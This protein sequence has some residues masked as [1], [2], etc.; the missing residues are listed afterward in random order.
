MISLLYVDDEPIFLDLAKRLLEVP[1]EFFV[2]TK[3]SA[4]EGLEALASG[5]F[6]AI[7]A[8][9]MMPEMDGIV[10]LQ[11][12]R[13]EF[14]KIPFIM[15]TGKGREEIVIRALNAGADFYLQ[16]TGKPQIVFSEL[17]HILKQYVSLQ[18]T[19]KS[20]LEREERYHDLQNANDLIQ[21]VG[22]DG[23]FLYVNKKWLD[24]LGYEEKD[25]AHLAIFD[26]IHQESLSHCMTTFRRVISGENVGIVDAIFK[27]RDGKKVYVEGIA[28]CKITDGK[29]QYTR[30]IFKDVTDR[31]TAEAAL[32]ESEE[33]FRT[34]V[35]TT[36]DIVWEVDKDDRYTYVSPQVLGI[37]GYTPEEVIG[38]SC[39]DLMAPGE[40]DNIR[41]QYAEMVS[42]GKPIVR[43]ENTNLHK[44]GR[45]VILETSGEPVHA[46]DGS[47]KGYR[48]I[49][50][51]ITERK[52]AEKAIHQSEQYLMTLL[53][54]LPA[55]V[56]VVDA[57]TH[58]I[59]RANASALKLS[60]A[61][62]NDIVG[63][64]CHQFICPSA[65]GQCPITDKGMTLDRSER[66]LLTA[67]GGQVPVLKSVAKANLNGQEVLVETFVDISDS[68]RAE[69][70][71]R[72][73]E[74]RY[75]MLVENANEAIFVIQDG[76]ICFANPKLEQMGKYTTEELAQRPF[77][78]FVH[79]D[80]RTMVGEQH[81]RR[82]TGE[83]L[84]DSYA[85]RILPK[86]GS[87]RWMEISSS[88]ITWNGRAA[89]LVLLSDITERRQVEEALHESEDKFRS[90]VEHALDGILILDLPGTIL[91]AN[92]A[93]ARTIEADEPA[94]FIGRNVMEFISPES[95]E[96]VMKDFM[97]VSQGHD[98]YLAH[99]SVTSLRGNRYWVES[100]GK[101][102]NFNKKPAILLSIRDIT[103]R[104]RAD[105]A[106][107]QANKQ[108]YLLSGITRHD[109]LN[110]LMALKGYLELS[111]EV[112]DN[113]EILSEYIKNE[114]LAANAIEHQ[115][116]FTKDYQELGVAAPVWQNVGECTRKAAARLPMRRIHV[117]VVPTDLEI[118][119]DP[120]FET[121]FY[122]LIDNS[123]RYGG[124]RMTTIR[125]SSQE[126]EDHLTLAF[127]DDGAGI[128]AEDKK[129]LFT[130]GFG[131]N[132]GL[133]LFLSR[134]ILAITGIMISENSVPG[135]GTRFEITVPNG[136]FRFTGSRE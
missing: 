92:N 12:V 113:P 11:Q 74:D 65:E 88:L 40:A 55:G 107:R 73:S 4:R 17:K 16:K 51:D 99:Y 127:E 38:K 57:V 128:A 10:F 135:K 35:E 117:D 50:R 90:L 69:E 75:R 97:Q 39:F 18:Q 59:L 1:G 124:D 47:F 29:P 134:E 102:I 104:K 76:R 8:D 30:G 85:F 14:G 6:D 21:S 68:K 44:D 45:Q 103:E 13:K 132:T 81:N 3:S 70:A 100:I 110:Q 78:E 94:G 26:I 41:K 48:G 37:L 95:R 23:R 62:V 136:A 32:R 121:V 114:Q 66:I 96:D 120:L 101:V 54:S 53:E 46:A 125:I 82:L 71:L 31:K 56:I 9:Y 34:L 52:R 131:K 93:A 91:F 19:E 5:H 49:D 119:A 27:T 20:I 61:S 122:N 108:L 33:R 63:K 86:D 64:V 7:V 118:F 67:S 130:R 115:I 22:P 80:D 87:V 105:D 112:I 98:A 84:K 24:R 129:R 72:E 60:G 2:D 25:L 79:P 83:S 126:S 106:L 15:L 111:P 116:K 133:G 109:I 42:A 36:R 89:V 28:N 58:T 77:L 43:L 123:L